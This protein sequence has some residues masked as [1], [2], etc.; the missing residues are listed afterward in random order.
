MSPQNFHPAVLAFTLEQPS[1]Y[2]KLESVTLS[3]T[4]LNLSLHSLHWTLGDV[5]Q[6]TIIIPNIL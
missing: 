5:V 2:W 3:C 1:N 6:R 4:S